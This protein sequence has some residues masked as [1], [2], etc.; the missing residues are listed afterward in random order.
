[1]YLAPASH[2]S[3]R[4]IGRCIYFEPKAGAAVDSLGGGVELWSGLFQ[5]VR[6]TQVCGNGRTLALRSV[7]LHDP[8]K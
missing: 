4:P 6:P 5:S 7:L 3:N 8:Q 2:C 1:M